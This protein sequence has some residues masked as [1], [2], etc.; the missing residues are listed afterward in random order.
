MFALSE[1]SLVI[2]IFYLVL[3]SNPNANET[4]LTVAALQPRQDYSSRLMANNA[5][6]LTVT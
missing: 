2:Y 1:H 3:E 4:N 5:D 6:C